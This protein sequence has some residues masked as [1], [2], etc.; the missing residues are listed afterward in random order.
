M[1]CVNPREIDLRTWGL[2]TDQLIELEEV[3]SQS[4][5]AG[6]SAASITCSAR[7]GFIGSAVRKLDPG[8]VGTV[9]GLSVNALTNAVKNATG[10]MTGAELASSI[11]RDTIIATCSMIGAVERFNPESIGATFAFQSM[12]NDR[13]GIL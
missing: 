1:R 11:S 9:A 10:G 8:V 5:R 6:V 3:V 13:M 12:T 4:L 7:A 2:A